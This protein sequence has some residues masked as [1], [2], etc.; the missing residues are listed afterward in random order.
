LGLG[1][2]HE[3]PNPTAPGTACRENIERSLFISADGWA[4][5]CIFVNIP[6]GDTDPG[7][8]VFGNVRDTDAMEI[9]RN[10]DFGHFRER[11]T[12]GDPDLPCRGCPRRFVA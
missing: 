4:S 10:A 11:L 12:R 8:R 1:F 6:T 7:R 2:H 5:P 3:L 9:W